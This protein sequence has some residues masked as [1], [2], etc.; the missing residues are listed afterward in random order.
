MGLAQPLPHYNEDE[1]LQMER[2]AASRHEFLD[3]LVYAMAG[4]SPNHSRI[5]VNLS[6]EV[7]AA[8]KGRNC[9][10]FS[11]NMKVRTGQGGLYSY[12]D[13]SVVCGEARFHDR[14]RDVLLNPIAI[15]EVLSPSTATYDENEK[16]QRYQTIESLKIY[17]LIS[18]IA[19]AVRLFERQDDGDWRET[20]IIGLESVLPLAALD[21]AIPLTEIYDRVEFVV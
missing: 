16:F 6:A 10:G 9:E 2:Q 15:F 17:V 1:Y 14:Y 11:P 19:P 20:A 13:L 7:R 3:G 8:F 21:C 12:P 18:Q 4:E 5:C